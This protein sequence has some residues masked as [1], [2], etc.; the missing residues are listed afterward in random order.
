MALL[1][2]NPRHL[3]M[4]LINDRPG[5]ST[6]ELIKTNRRRLSLPVANPQILVSDWL[7][8]IVCF[9]YIL[10]GGIQVKSLRTFFREP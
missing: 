4:S 6:Y 8:V 10:L 2:P 9:F 5:F 1:K 7:S 3:Q